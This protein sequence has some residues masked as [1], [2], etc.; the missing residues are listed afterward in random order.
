MRGAGEYV[1]AAMMRTA[2]AVKVVIGKRLTYRELAAEQI[3]L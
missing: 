3:P 1:E 2:R